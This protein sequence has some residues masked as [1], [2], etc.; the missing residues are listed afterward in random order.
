LIQCKAS[1]YSTEGLGH[2]PNSP[3]SHQDWT[4]LC[5]PCIMVFT[6]CDLWV[7]SLGP[8]EKFCV[9]LSLCGSFMLCIHRDRPTSQQWWCLYFRFL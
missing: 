6:T 2:L 3:G 8:E 1:T 4:E 5:C 7:C 9:T